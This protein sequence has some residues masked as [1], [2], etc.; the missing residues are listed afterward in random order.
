[1]YSVDS[2]ASLYCYAAAM[3]CRL[4]G[5]PNYAR[6]SIEMVPLIEAA[7]NSFIMDW[8]TILS[9]KMASQIL[10]YRGNIFVTTQVVPPFYMNA[11]I[12]DTIYFNSAFP[13]LGWKWIVQDPTP[14]HIYHKYLW[15]FDYNNHIYRICHVFVLLVH[16]AIFNEHAPR[17]SDKA[18]IDLNSIGS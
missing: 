7:V 13:I 6:F 15:K 11:Y 10:D 4:F 14:I 9:N 1:M 8:E 16:Q 5:S 2:L 18:S 12:M 3:V 17:V